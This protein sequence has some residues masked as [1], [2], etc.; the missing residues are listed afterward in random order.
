VRAEADAHRNTPYEVVRTVDANDATTLKTATVAVHW[1]DR[2]GGA[3]QAVLSSVI[4][5]SNPALSTALALPR[6]A[7]PV[8]GAFD[9][10]V[11]IPLAAR[12]LGNGSSV[13]KPTAS[14]TTAYLFDNATGQITARCT[15]VM[16]TDPTLADLSACSALS[17]MLLSGQIRFSNAAPPDAASANDTPLPLSVQLTL[18]GGTYPAA[19]SCSSEAQKTVAFES[20][21]GTR[22]RAVPIDALP[23]SVGVANWVELGERFVAYHC[24][25]T[26]LNGGWSGRSSLVPQGWTLGSTGNERKVCRY[27]ADHD[28]SGAVDSNAE[29]PDSYSHVD[30]TLSQQNFLVIRGDQSCPAGHVD[31]QG[32]LAYSNLSTVQ[33]QP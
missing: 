7:D 16:G 2:S 21:A 28:G 12:D 20:P 14:G 19:P 23:A 13:F 1:T 29:H 22:H 18:T 15:I 33:H 32:S 24:V 11:R 26:P 3:R 27:S 8:R 10:S 9:R 25:V 6:S 5:R 4:S 17:G 31:A 30:A